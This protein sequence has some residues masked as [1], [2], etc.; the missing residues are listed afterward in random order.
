MLEHWISTFS[1]PGHPSTTCMNL[2]GPLVENH[3]CSCHPPP[4]VENHCL[5]L[6]QCFSIR[7]FLPV[8]AFSD[9]PKAGRIRELRSF[10]AVGKTSL[11]L[12][13]GK[14]GKRCGREREGEY[15]HLPWVSSHPVLSAGQWTQLLQPS[16]FIQDGQ[17]K[18][19]EARTCALATGQFHLPSIP[20]SRRSIWGQTKKGYS[21]TQGI[22][23]CCETLPRV[24]QHPGWEP[25]A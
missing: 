4:P 20:V 14:R 10:F 8:L 16:W 1:E 21:I 13:Q 22:T 17:C 15:S 11:C 7:V 23:P 24:P 6:P 9:E 2:S 25:L 19:A 3:C 18:R 5:L 12:G